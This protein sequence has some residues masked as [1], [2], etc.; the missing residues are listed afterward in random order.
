MSG[1]G[2]TIAANVP[3]NSLLEDIPEVETGREAAGDFRKIHVYPLPWY[4]LLDAENN[5][6]FIVKPCPYLLLKNS[7]QEPAE[8]FI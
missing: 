8:F 2:T 1:L 6:P 4:P 3:I 5:N 7:G